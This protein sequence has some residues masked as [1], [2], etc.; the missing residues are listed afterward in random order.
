MVK[1]PRQPAYCGRPENSTADP[2]R[3]ATLIVCFLV[4]NTPQDVT[5]DPIFWYLLNSSRRRTKAR[6]ARSM[7]MLLLYP[8]YTF[9]ICHECGHTTP[10]FGISHLPVQE[11]RGGS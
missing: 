7:V 5:L 9:Q 1:P 4:G 6:E 11:L 10:H 3:S 8:R 2:L